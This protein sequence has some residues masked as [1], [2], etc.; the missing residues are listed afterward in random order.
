MH[1]HIQQYVKFYFHNNDFQSIVKHALKLLG[2]L[3]A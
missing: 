2:F 3:H 1:I